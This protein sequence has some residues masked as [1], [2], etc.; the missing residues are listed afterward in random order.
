MKLGV[1]CLLLLKFKNKVS[2]NQLFD[3]EC[4]CCISVYG[5]I[6]VDLERSTAEDDNNNEEETPLTLDEWVLQDTSIWCVNLC[7]G[8]AE[9]DN[10]KEAETEY[11]SALWTD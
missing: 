7:R 8:V 4:F 6:C 2:L 1:A 9:V 5:C 11:T 3:W 10:N